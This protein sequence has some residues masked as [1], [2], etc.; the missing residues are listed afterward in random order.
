MTIQQVMKQLSISYGDI[1]DAFGYKDVKSY[2]TSTRRPKIE[3]GVIDIYQRTLKS[4]GEKNM[5]DPAPT[6]DEDAQT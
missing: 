1:S 5:I 4:V 6:T 3:A 2:Y